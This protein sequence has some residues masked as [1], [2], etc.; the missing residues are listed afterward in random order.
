MTA[1]FDPDSDWVPVRNL[2]TRFD[3][4]LIVSELRANGVDSRIRADDTGGWSP[5]LSAA[6][7]VIVLV[8]KEDLATAR[9]ALQKI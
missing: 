9:S 7:G 8:R 5:E 2:T 1:H 4:E 6:G 3:A